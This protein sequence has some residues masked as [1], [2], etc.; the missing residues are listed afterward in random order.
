VKEDI[1]TKDST[2]SRRN[3]LKKGAFLAAPLAA[4][5]PAVA[6]ADD[7]MKAR[8]KRLEDES[9]IR[10]AHQAWLRQVNTGASGDVPF[11]ETI[12]RITVDNE[13]VPDVVEIASDELRATGRYACVADVETPIVSDCTIAQMAVAQGHGTMLRTG[14]GVLTV[15]YAKTGTAWAITKAKFAWT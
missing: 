13:G 6:L 10:E 9:A 5:M 1:V 11:D 2:S 14:R 7:G 8:L 4:A 12:R 15:A 3:F